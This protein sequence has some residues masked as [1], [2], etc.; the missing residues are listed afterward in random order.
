[1]VELSIST[2]NTGLY[3]PLTCLVVSVLFAALAVYLVKRYF[4]TRQNFTLLFIAL[5]AEIVLFTSVAFLVV[6]D[7]LNYDV[8][9]ILNYMFLVS[10]TIVAVIGLVMLEVKSFYTLPLFVAALALLNYNI[11]N[12]NYTQVVYL[13]QILSYAYTRQFIGNPLFI[14][15]KIMFPNIAP[16]S[17]TTSIILNLLFNPLSIIF[18]NNATGIM[19]LYIAAIAI[20]TTVLFYILAWRNK[21]GRPL[22]FALGLTTYIVMGFLTNTDLIGFRSLAMMVLI[23]IGLAF[24]AAGVLGLFDKLTKRKEPQI[25]QVKKR[26][27]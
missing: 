2:L 26:K 7:I 9:P 4:E 16:A 6:T 18:S 17:Q 15:L 14:T 20:P 11:L 1:M 8:L 19:D 5:F 27:T 12:S 21:S 25:S 10:A 22:G 3:E 13:I 23:L 24:F